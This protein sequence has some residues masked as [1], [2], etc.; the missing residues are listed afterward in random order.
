LATAQWLEERL[1]EVSAYAR[2]YSA[3]P[4]GERRSESRAERPVPLL[5]AQEILQMPQE[6]VLAFHR[7]LPPARLRRANWLEHQALID[8]QGLAV[9]V[10]CEL[11]PAPTL[12]LRS[13]AASA[14]PQLQSKPIPSAGATHTVTRPAHQNG[15]QLPL[16]PDAVRKTWHP[17]DP[18]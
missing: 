9:P 12:S 4:F 8:R 15:Y 18:Q 5:S 17:E 16:D 6:S 7:D 11:P 13:D 1:G 2:S 3:T 14:A 10:I